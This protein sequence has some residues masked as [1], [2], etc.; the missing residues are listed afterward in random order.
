MGEPLDIIEAAIREYGP[1]RTVLVARTIA[2]TAARLRRP[3]TPAEVVAAVGGRVKPVDE[4]LVR[5][6][7]AATGHP[8]Y[9]GTPEPEP[10]RARAVDP[11]DPFAGL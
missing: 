1:L 10:A 4:A 8:L 5:A 9:A 7:A 6:I 11:N 3:P 2:I